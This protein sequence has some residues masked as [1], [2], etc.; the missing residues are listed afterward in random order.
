MAVNWTTVRITLASIGVFVGV[1][2]GVWFALE[3]RNYN[4]TGFALVSSVFATF[5]LTLHVKYKRAT[6]HRWAGYRLRFI[7]VCGCIGQLAGF[8]GFFTYMSLAIV[9]RQSL[10]QIYGENYWIALVWAWM[11]WKWGFGLFW[12][13]RKYKR[14]FADKAEMEAMLGGGKGQHEESGNAV[15]ASSDGELIE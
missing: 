13:A 7:S 15:V 1:L 2:A 3:Y 8:T 11:T 5:T 12:Y 6:L 9:L 4:A 14:E 10:S